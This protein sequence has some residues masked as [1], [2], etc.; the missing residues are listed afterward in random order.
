MTALSLITRHGVMTAKHVAEGAK[1]AGY[2]VTCPELT[3][4]SLNLP[5]AGRKAGVIF[6]FRNVSA[7]L[8][9]HHEVII[10]INHHRLSDVPTKLRIPPDY[11]VSSPHIPRGL[12]ILHIHSPDNILPCFHMTNMVSSIYL[13]RSD[14]NRAGYSHTH[15]LNFVW[16]SSIRSLP[17]MCL[18]LL[19]ALNGQERFP[20]LD[21]G[22]IGIHLIFIAQLAAY[23]VRL[24]LPEVKAHPE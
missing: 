9:I 7:R 1:H 14:N 17:G 3:F 12:H 6:E 16:A 20:G 13:R 5:N 18:W 23:L 19:H 8:V 11:Y 4:S 10:S 2:R 15:L 22:I 24:K 21:A